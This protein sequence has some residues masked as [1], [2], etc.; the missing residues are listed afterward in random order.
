LV[1]LIVL[2]PI[3]AGINLEQMTSSSGWK[4]CPIFLHVLDKNVH[5]CFTQWM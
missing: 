4:R 5:L 2:L 3:S 1:S